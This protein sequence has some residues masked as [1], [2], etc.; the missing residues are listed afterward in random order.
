MTWK[1]KK[2]PLAGGAE[3]V[4]EEIAKRLVKDGNQVIFLVGGFKGG[5]VTETV[6]GYKVIRV[7]NRWTTYWKAYLYY[8][9]HLKGWADLVVEE[10]NTIP[11]LTKYYVREE[12]K[13]M[14]IYQLC[15]EI[16]F[17]QMIFPLNVIGYLLEPLYLR[18][19]SDQKVITISKST[20]DDLIKHHF[21]SNNISIM[22][23]G[24]EIP[25]LPTLKARGIQ[26]SFTL[27]SLGAIRAMKRTDEQ[28][29]AFEIL[30]KSIP[31]AKLV[32][33]GTGNGSYYKKV[34]NMIETSQYQK[35]IT[36]LGSV[37]NDKRTQ[38]MQDADV[39]LVTS[40]KE[41][42]GLIVTEA[43]SQGTPAVVYNVDGLRD[44]VINNVTGLVTKENT[45]QALATEIV[46][47][48]RDKGNYQKM[49]EAAWEKSK[50]VTFDRCYED[51]VGAING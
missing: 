26:K 16:W 4:N 46:A 15:R 17:H 33:A 44:S 47:L 25:P 27:L 31:T 18:L 6:N 8:K 36:Y 28:L 37:D 38:L 43:G 42:W 45:P 40:V 10:M 29:R 1:D 5:T 35:D 14:I 39:I 51:F 41:G 49:R 24:I 34:I 30:K 13:V 19:L 12:K 23:V 2:N 7:G 11:F 3:T 21:R 20:K 22:S 9:K 32:I 50:T 48:H